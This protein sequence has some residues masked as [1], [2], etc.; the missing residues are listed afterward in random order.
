MATITLP[1]ETKQDAVSVKRCRFCGANVQH[2]FVDLG[3]SPLCETYPSRTELNHGETYYPL[4]VYVCDT[5]FLVQLEEYERAENIFSDYAY[6]SSYSDSWLRHAK[7]YCENMRSRFGLGEDSFVVEVASNDG[8]L[9]QYFVQHNI[10][11]LG[12]EPAANVAKVAVE[13][14]VPTLVSF[15]GTRLA[16]ELVR[17][18][19]SADL[20]LGNNVLAQVPDL[21]DF[22]EGLKV[23]LKPEGVLTLEFPHLLK[24]IEKNEFD[25]IYHEHFSYFSMLT[26]VRIMEAHGLKVFDV[27]ELPSHGGSLRVFACRA[28]SNNHPTA[29]NVARVIEDEEKAGLDSVGGYERFAR[30][31]KDTKLALV[32][33]LVKAAREGKSVAGYGAPGKSATLLHYCGIGRDLIEYT[34]DRSPY[35]QGRFLP[36][37]H[38][39]IHHPDRIRETKPEYV[40]IL[41]WNLK[42]EIIKQLE[43][44]R[45]WG[46]SF[47]VPIPKVTIC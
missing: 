23:L 5:C 38:I 43:F 4:H 11:V 27:E 30:E 14:G 6:F 46:G 36:G 40:V 1:A 31:V 9:L 39:P 34:V 10:P 21:N 47:V 12:I 13:K 24:L 25:T 15:F 37:T 32:D 16:E 26:T 8:Y 41:P 35:K 28:G 44:I 7:S 2:T 3:M 19:Q 17:E 20:V 29:P 33:F 42:D 22:V 45:E 18:E